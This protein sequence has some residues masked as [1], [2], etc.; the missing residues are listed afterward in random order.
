MTELPCFNRLV[1]AAGFQEL[2]QYFYMFNKNS[3]IFINILNIVLN[4]FQEHEN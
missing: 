3:Y 4:I 2:Y 1:V